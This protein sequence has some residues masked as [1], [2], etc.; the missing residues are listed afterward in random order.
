MGLREPKVSDFT[1]NAASE[2]GNFTVSATVTDNILT[3]LLVI[4]HVVEVCCGMQIINS[5]LKIMAEEKAK[6]EK[7]SIDIDEKNEKDAEGEKNTYT[8]EV[9]RD[10]LN[11]ILGMKESD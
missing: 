4:P 9:L 7:L 11:S 3:S 10:N 2:I 8:T 5:Y 1:T 6:T